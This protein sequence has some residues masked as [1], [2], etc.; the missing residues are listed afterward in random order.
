MT[1]A[2]A[3]GEHDK[4]SRQT[5]FEGWVERQDQLSLWTGT[6]FAFA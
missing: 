1:F 5:S 2:V 6:V 4:N 3:C